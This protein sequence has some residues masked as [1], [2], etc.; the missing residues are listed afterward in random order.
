MDAIDTQRQQAQLRRWRRWVPLVHWTG[1]LTAIAVGVGAVVTV[2]MLVG[3]QVWYWGYTLT[4]SVPELHQ[5]LAVPPP[6][7]I[8]TAI[9]NSGHVMRYAMAAITVAH[10]LTPASKRLVR[11]TGLPVKLLPKD[12]PA[13][14][15][16]NDL[17]KAQRVRRPKVYVVHTA[18]IMA[19]AAS[20]PFQRSVIVISDGLL[21]QAPVEMSRW[22][23]AHEVA[24]L[25]YGDTK[26][27]GPWV[28]AVNALMLI[29]RV[30]IAVTR[31]ALVI[32]SRIPFF[33]RLL[34]PLVGRPMVLI[35]RLLGVVTAIGYRTAAMIYR[36]FDRWVARQCEYR[37]DQF[38]AVHAGLEPGIQLMKT[39]T[40]HFEPQFSMMATH[41]TPKQRAAALQLL[42]P[43]PDYPSVNPEEQHTQ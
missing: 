28:I 22:V 21:L 40:G 29:D 4:L 3:Q 17:C 35:S 5:A 31:M 41:P 16:V 23:L 7:S 11:Q 25:A 6:P 19:Y 38:A 14:I 9:F 42:A 30:R 20:A 36:L 18:G 27:S 39:L 32:L 8:K 12:H 26:R 2:P 33:R 43:I 37:A 13:R 24:H 34:V 10:F 1:T 15:Y